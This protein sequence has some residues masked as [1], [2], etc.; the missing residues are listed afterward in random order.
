MSPTTMIAEA[1][2]EQRVA[3]LERTVAEFQHQ[4]AGTPASENWLEKVTGSIN[5]EAAFQEALEY[6]RELRQADRPSSDSGEEP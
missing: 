4:L 1:T 6:G 5:D 2:I 3:A